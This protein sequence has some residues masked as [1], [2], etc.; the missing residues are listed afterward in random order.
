MVYIL[1]KKYI[2][3]A[4]IKIPFNIEI[5]LKLFPFEQLIVKINFL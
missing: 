1:H 3:K 2:M 4:I 5:I